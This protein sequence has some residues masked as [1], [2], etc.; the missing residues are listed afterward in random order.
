MALLRTR[1][2]PHFIRKRFGLEIA[3]THPL[4]ASAASY[5]VGAPHPLAAKGCSLMHDDMGNSDAAAASGPR[6]PAATRLEVKRRSSV[7]PFAGMVPTFAHVCVGDETFL[8]GASFGIRK[9]APGRFRTL[10]FALDARGKP[11]RNCFAIPPRDRVKPRS[12]KSREARAKMYRTTASGAYFVTLGR[13]DGAV[14]IVI[15][16]LDETLWIVRFDGRQFGHLRRLKYNGNATDKRGELP[17]NGADERDDNAGRH[18]F[19]AALPV[20]SDTVPSV[21]N[22]TAAYWWVTNRGYVGVADGA[23]PGERYVDLNNQYHNPGT[24]GDESVNNSIAVGAKGAFVVTNRALYRFVYREGRV[25]LVW[26]HP[27]EAPELGVQSRRLNTKGTGTTPTVLGDQYVAFTDGAARMRLV[28]VEQGPATAQLAPNYRGQ[29]P[30]FVNYPVLGAVAG[31]GTEQTACENS[32]V[33]F[34]RRDPAGATWRILVGNTWGYVTPFDDI[35]ARDADTQGFEYV[36]LGA[37]ASGLKLTRV[38]ASRINVG[39]AVPKLSLSDRVVYVYSFDRSATSMTWSLVGLDVEGGGAECYRR[40]VF[41]DHRDPGKPY[42]VSNHDNA[43]GTMVLTGGGAAI[44]AWR[45]MR[46]IQD[47]T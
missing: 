13:R 30:A 36:E 24:S 28:V 7:F 14:D 1:F 12:L 15:P 22:S 44:A 11:V 20:W 17:T 21:D 25:H 38:W 37:E 46:W 23:S 29:T 3:A 34:L 43:W 33:G 41:D 42:K 35:E 32:L 4:V 40:T 45:G 39:T 8:I 26:R 9:L 19:V 10:L 6:N 47:E 31:Q 2:L 27:Y 18:A 16:A 5:E